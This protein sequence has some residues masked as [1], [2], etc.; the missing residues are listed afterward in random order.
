MKMKVKCKDI[1]GQKQVLLRV[2]MAHI[3]KS[4]DK[5]PMTL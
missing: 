2:K 4:E 5:F 1:K 3:P